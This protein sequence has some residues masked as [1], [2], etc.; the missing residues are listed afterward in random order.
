MAAEPDIVQTKNAGL[1]VG[2][3]LAKKVDA[4]GWIRVT[5]PREHMTVSASVTEAG[6]GCLELDGLITFTT[7]RANTE[8][9]YIEFITP[10]A[11]TL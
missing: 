1:S 5:F 2:W 7:C 11:L 9:N 8:K 6:G 3:A 10:T 4:G